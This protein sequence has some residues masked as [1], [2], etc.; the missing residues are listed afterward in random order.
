MYQ[1]AIEKKSSLELQLL[2]EI[3]LGINSTGP[4]GSVFPHCITPSIAAKTQLKTWSIFS[5]S[6]SEIQLP[7][8]FFFLLNFPSLSQPNCQT[9]LAQKVSDQF[10]NHGQHKN[11]M[12][13]QQLHTCIC[14]AGTWSWAGF[15]K[16]AAHL[17]SSFRQRQADAQGL[18]LLQSSD[19]YPPLLSES[20]RPS[21]FT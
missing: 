12:Q 1:R 7:F 19:F 5:F 20:L 21:E 3:V 18:Q 4:R 2:K 6:C 15:D 8:F 14:L 9:S 17:S 11:V 16:W 13:K 10:I